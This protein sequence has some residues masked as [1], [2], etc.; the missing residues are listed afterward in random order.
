MRF[1]KIFIIFLAF[2]L[3]SCVSFKGTTKEVISNHYGQ[4]TILEKKGEYE[5]I[6][7]SIP[8]KPDKICI[9]KGE[10][11]IDEFSVYKTDKALKLFKDLSESR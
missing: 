10:N 4:I 11:V 7:V 1:Y 9:V 5:L 8:H 2:S 6:K 3:F